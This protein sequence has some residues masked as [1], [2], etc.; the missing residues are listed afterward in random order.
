[1]RPYF[2]DNST[3][4]F[5]DDLL[6][7]KDMPMLHVYV[8]VFDDATCI[9]FHLPHAFGDMLGLGLIMRAWAK[10]VNAEDMK[11]VVLPEVMEGDP[12]ADWADME[13]PRTPEAQAVVKANTTMHLYGLWGTLRYFVPLAFSI[14]THKETSRSL[15][16]PLS[17]IDA[18]RSETMAGDEKARWVSENDI[19]T[20]I[21]TYVSSLSSWSNAQLS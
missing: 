3:P 2:R 16:I 8:N 4:N 1:M 6:K 20:A 9:G 7:A 21:L 19:V 11:S 18:L 15:F 5:L 17:V 14:L 12:L 13:Y 10:L